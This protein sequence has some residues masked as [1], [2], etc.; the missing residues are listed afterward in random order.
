MP[1]CGVVF[2][3]FSLIQKPTFCWSTTAV[4]N[5]LWYCQLS[6]DEND[7]DDDEDE[8]FFHDKWILPTGWINND[9]SWIAQVRRDKSLS[10]GTI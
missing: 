7:D 5:F 1:F 4:K 3:Y 6:N 10:L 2:F 9:G 8:E